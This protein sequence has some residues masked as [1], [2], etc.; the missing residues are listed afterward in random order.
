MLFLQI[1]FKTLQQNKQLRKQLLLLK[2]KYKFKKIKILGIV[3]TPKK[4]KIFTVLRSPHVNKQ[5]REQFN[6]QSHNQKIIIKGFTIFHLFNF[7]ILL[8]NTMTKNTVIQ[9]KIYQK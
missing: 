5:S 4:N 6:F 2:K 7:L 1:T 8:K 3:S 9:T